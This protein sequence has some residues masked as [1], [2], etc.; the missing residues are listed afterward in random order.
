VALD[1]SAEKD[2]AAERARKLEKGWPKLEISKQHELITDVLRRVVIGQTKIWIE[3]NPIK[4]AEAL[5][6]HKLGSNITVNQSEPDIIKLAADFKPH[7]RGSELCLLVPKNSSSE[8]IP[9]ASLVK[10]VAHARDWYEKIVAGEIGT[11]VQLAQK[12]GVGSTYAKRILR[13]ATISPK[14]AEFILS[15]NHRPDL[16]LQD[17]PRTIPLDWRKQIGMLRRPEDTKNIK[18]RSENPFMGSPL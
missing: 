16:T 15:G 3:F 7:R 12:T 14:I 5:L 13:Y 18:N 17:L 10:A 11:I 2:V 8:G 4:L 1:G 6:G 9:N